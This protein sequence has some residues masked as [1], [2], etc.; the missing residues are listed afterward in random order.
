M[1]G[2]PKDSVELYANI[3]RSLLGE[4]R[5]PEAFAQAGEKAAER[6]FNIIKCAPFDDIDSENTT[7]GLL[8]AAKIGIA[9]VAA[10]RSAVGP[11]VEVLVDCHRCFDQ[12][13]SLV[14]AGE[15]ANLGIGWFEEPMCW[16]PA[17]V[18]HFC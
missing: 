1:G 11:N 5:T 16:Q 9:R 4:N 17:K 18:G 8:E 3:N 15:L 10:V 14:V 7:K 2:E 13:S 12:D 6:G